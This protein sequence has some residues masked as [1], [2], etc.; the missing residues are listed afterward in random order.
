MKKFV[1][2]VSFTPSM[3]PSF[4]PVDENENIIIGLSITTDV[5][6]GELV[7]VY[8]QEGGELAQ[9]WVE[10]HPDWYKRYS[11]PRGDDDTETPC[12][13]DAGTLPGAS[14]RRNT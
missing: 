13:D 2:D 14:D 8:H 6:P 11:R 4:V 1:L 5:C 9:K 7:G 12:S 10:E 3:P